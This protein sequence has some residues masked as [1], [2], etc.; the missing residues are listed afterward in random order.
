MY[1][2]GS[3]DQFLIDWLPGCSL[4]ESA[5]AVAAFQLPFLES[6]AVA[7]NHLHL[8]VLVVFM[9][10]KILFQELV[11]FVGVSQVK[12]KLL[13]LYGV[14]PC[15]N[16]FCTSHLVAN[17]NCTYLLKHVQNIRFCIPSNLLVNAT[18]Y[19]GTTWLLPSLA[20][21]PAALAL[22]HQLVFKCSQ[23]PGTTFTC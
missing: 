19:L 9:F 12:G 5:G 11:M 16:T 14:L 21:S 3:F 20:A 6:W 22:T 4:S 2:T 17:L 15:Q 13:D 7:H 8:F 23:V 1:G 18:R 10:L